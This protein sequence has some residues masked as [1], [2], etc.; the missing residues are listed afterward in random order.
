[1]FIRDCTFLALSVTKLCHDS[2]GPLLLLNIDM[3]TLTGRVQ[4]D[5]FPY[6]KTDPKILA[7]ESDTVLQMYQ[8]K[9]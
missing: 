2:G 3:Q 5:T 9:L 6:R 8:S 7:S 1:M 4:D